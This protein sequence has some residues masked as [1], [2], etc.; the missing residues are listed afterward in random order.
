MWANRSG[1][2]PKM[3]EWAN[4]SFFERIP[5][6]LIFSQKTS[7]SLRKP[8]SEFPALIFSLLYR[9]IGLSTCKGSSHTNVCTLSGASQNRTYVDWSKITSMSAQELRREVGTLKI[10]TI[11]QRIRKM[12]RVTFPGPLCRHKEQLICSKIVIFLSFLFNSTMAD[13]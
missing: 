1:C 2:S 5:H 9:V 11:W 7:D 8:M 13:L 4:R 12:S 10:I 6:S 3:S